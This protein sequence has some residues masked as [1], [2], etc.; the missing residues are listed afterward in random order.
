MLTNK[1]QYDILNVLQETKTK[2]AIVAQLVE[3][4]LAKVGVASSNLVYR[5]SKKL[6]ELFRKLFAYIKLCKG[7][8]VF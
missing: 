8:K 7:Q 6:S 5:S 1:T 4:D 3:H 2:Y